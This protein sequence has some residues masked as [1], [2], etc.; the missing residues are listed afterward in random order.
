MNKILLY[1]K[2]IDWVLFFSVVLLMSF[3]LVEIYSI[4]LSHGGN[5]LDNFHKQIIFIAIGVV[6]TLVLSFVDYNNYISFGNLLYAFGFFLLLGVLLFG[7]V[8]RGTQGWYDIFGFM[9]LQPVEFAKII[10][11]IF[12]AKYF[13]SNNI[14]NNPLKHL[15][16]TG[17]STLG[18]VLLV[19]KQPDFGSALLL[20]GIWGIMLMFSGFN[21]KYILGLFFIGL[22]LFSSGW[23]FFFKDYQKER[24]MTFIRPDTGSLE[25][26]YNIKQATI[27]IGAGGLIGR[28][29]GFGSQS[30]L[31]FLP[32]SQNDF[33]FAVISEELGFLG[34]CLVLGFF[35]IF[36]LRLVKSARNTSNNFGIYF[37]LGTGALIFIE[38]F[39]NIGMN[40][41]LLPVVGISLPFL[42]YGGS[43]I[44]ASLTLMGIC[45]NIIIQSKLKY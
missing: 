6:I 21:K 11:I 32:E 24:I 39:I 22:I 12:L 25:E 35:G 15:T 16:I 26:G 9:S 42:S 28:G 10:L 41:G 27:A 30:Q 8:V 13:S 44:L 3:G 31:K 40:I 1:F 4:A 37:L 33:I 36:Y 14:Q 38:M 34:V 23:F 45:Q 5:N 20:V 18:F 19:L 29:V 2:K 7:K 43:A 17:L